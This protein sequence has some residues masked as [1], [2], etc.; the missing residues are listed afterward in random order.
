[1]VFSSP[2]EEANAAA[3]KILI[4]EDEGI[5]ADNIATS[6]S[7][8]GYKVAGI[9]ASSEEAFAILPESTPDLVLMDI[10]IKGEL[11]GI[12]PARKLRDLFDIPVIY[13]TAH[14]DPETINRAKLTGGFGF[15]TKPI[16]HRT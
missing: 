5:I 9:A 4:V 1:M 2:R 16:D 15:L 10:R 6:L 3:A 13:L 12:E 8:S 7:R 11:D 14:T